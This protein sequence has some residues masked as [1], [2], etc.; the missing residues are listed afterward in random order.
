MSNAETPKL[1]FTSSA[2]PAQAPI[3]QLNTDPAQPPDG[4]T[5]SVIGFGKVS[6]TGDVSEALLETT[7][8][9]VPQA[10]CVQQITSVPVVETL[11]ICAG[12]PEG[13]R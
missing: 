11:Q 8:D 3:I 5:L 9:V 12:I 4:T 6:E 13:G 2:A 1:H 10:T 7:V